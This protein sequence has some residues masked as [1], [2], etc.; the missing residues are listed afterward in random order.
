MSVS[1]TNLRADVD[2]LI[3]VVSVDE[4]NT[5]E[6]LDNKGGVIRQYSLPNNS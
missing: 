2:K 3:Y 1:Y 4:W 5:I 6:V